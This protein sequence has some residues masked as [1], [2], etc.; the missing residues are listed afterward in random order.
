MKITYRDLKKVILTDI[1]AGGYKKKNPFP[2]T[3]Y[4][5]R[6]IKS[7]R[8]AEFFNNRFF[9]LKY[10]FLLRYRILELRYMTFIP[11]YT[12]GPGLS[13]AH[14]GNIRINKK[15]KIGRFCRIQE[16]VTIGA[17]NNS[18]NAPIIGNFV[19]I[20]SGAK[21]IGDISISPNCQI[22][23]GSVVV[24]N[25]KESGTYAGVPAKKISNNCSD[26][27]LQIDASEYDIYKSVLWYD[28][29]CEVEKNDCN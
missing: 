14:I 2:F 24:K 16:G 18:L 7:L 6:L 3:D 27:N 15:A 22:G 21:I 9:I 28:T 29:N 10:Y 25:I 8:Y 5:L 17:T 26:K 13:I 4:E 11:L 20:G 23:A 1:K 12:C 19:Y